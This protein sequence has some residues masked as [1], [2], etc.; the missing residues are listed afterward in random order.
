MIFL[1]IEEKTV[2]QFTSRIY[3]RLQLITYF[4]VG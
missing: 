3:Q 1:L 4:M 2:R